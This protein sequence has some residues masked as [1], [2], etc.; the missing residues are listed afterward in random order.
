MLLGLM[1]KEILEDRIKELGWS[2]YRLTQ[3]FCKERGET[4]DPSS[5]K[6]FGSAVKRALQN[7][8]KSSMENIERLIKAMGGE[9]V[10][11]WTETE[12][13][14]TGHREVEL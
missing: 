9:L 8:S 14:V 13:V 1:K 2:Q 12:E 10:I 5:V 4:S 7:P 11:R 3:E 6:R